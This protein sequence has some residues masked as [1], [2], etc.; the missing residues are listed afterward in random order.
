MELELKARELAQKR[1]TEKVERTRI[2]FNELGASLKSQGL[3]KC[4]EAD[5]THGIFQSIEL[6]ERAL[7]ITEGISNPRL[8]RFYLFM[9]NYKR[10]LELRAQGTPIGCE[11]EAV[12]SFCKPIDLRIPYDP[13]LFEE[14]IRH[15]I[16]NQSYSQRQS[17]LE[18][19]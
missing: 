13:T 3:A 11:Y 14:L 10:A 19:M 2:L 6:P 4:V 1:R 17:C 18:L 5:D 15:K 16:F 8:G 7:L 9:L 12:I